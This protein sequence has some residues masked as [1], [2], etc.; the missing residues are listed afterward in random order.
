MQVDAAEPKKA[1]LGYVE[2]AKQQEQKAEAE[3]VKTLSKSTASV[4]LCIEVP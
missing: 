1:Q 2:L 4:P 3:Q